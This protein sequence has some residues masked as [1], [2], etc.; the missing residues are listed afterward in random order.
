MIDTKQTGSNWAPEL[1]LVLVNDPASKFHRYSYSLG[2]TAV[3]VEMLFAYSSL[4]L[5]VIS[6]ALGHPSDS[7][8]EM[9]IFKNI[10]ILMLQI[11]QSHFSEANLF[12]LIRT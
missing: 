12:E 6:A 11:F 10:F 7:Q 4:I 8:G 2:P 5:A 9:H 3:R 1:L